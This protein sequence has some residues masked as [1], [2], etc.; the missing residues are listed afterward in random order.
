MT[1]KVCA[2]AIISGRVQG[3]FY[4]LE[5][6]RAAEK[7]GVSG[8]VKNLPD[9]RVEAIMTGDKAAVESLIGWCR[10]GPPA[11]RVK[12]VDVQ[13]KDDSGRYSGFDVVY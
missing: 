6:K 12:R 8:W 9:G 4:R 11:A 10:Q 5:T 7:R 1:E 3:V 13:W 2:R